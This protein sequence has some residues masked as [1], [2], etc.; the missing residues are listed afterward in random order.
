MPLRLNYM[1]VFLTALLICLQSFFR[2]RF[3]FS[4]FH[5]IFSAFILHTFICTF[6]RL[7]EREK[8]ANGT[9]TFLMRLK[10]V[11]ADDYSLF[12]DYSRIYT[13][14]MEYI[15][16]FLL[17]SSK[18]ILCWKMFP[19]SSVVVVVV[20]HVQWSSF[21]KYFWTSCWPL[22]KRKCR[23]FVKFWPRKQLKI[24]RKYEVS[25]ELGLKN[26]KKKVWCC[27]FRSNVYKI[28]TNEQRKY[29]FIS[30]VFSS[31]SFT[32]CVS[33]KRISKLRE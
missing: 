7:M 16:E 20:L 4:H 30:F 18:T 19:F 23:S 13:N 22:H 29:G 28:H 10:H 26:I 8:K 2:F 27:F 25:K 9:Q 1:I 24:Q 17:L 15:S 33:V 6:P 3:F 5:S 14:T 12:L 31:A 21:C 32:L 11:E